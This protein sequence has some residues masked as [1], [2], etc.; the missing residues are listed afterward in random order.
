MVLN[1]CLGCGCCVCMKVSPLNF[2]GCATINLLSYLL[3]CSI[4]RFAE[5]HRIK[6]MVVARRLWRVCSCTKRAEDG[7][8][9]STEKS[10]SSGMMRYALRA[11]SNLN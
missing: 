7:R 4:S 11:K 2:C 8:Y 9:S 5:T 1:C 3:I 6:D 10:N